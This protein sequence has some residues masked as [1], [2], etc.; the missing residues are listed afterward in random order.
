MVLRPGTS[1]RMEQMGEELDPFGDTRAGPRKVGVSV[2]RIDRGARNR[3]HR[4]GKLDRAIEPIAAWRND[5]QLGLG[6]TDVMPRDALRVGA[7]L[8][9]RLVPARYA[10]P[11]RNPVARAEEW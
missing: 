8:S 9:D 7:R 1:R 10:N 5:D 11:L 3:R 6:F 4:A 2:N